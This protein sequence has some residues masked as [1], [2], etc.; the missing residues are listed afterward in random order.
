MKKTLQL[1]CL[2]TGPIWPDLLINKLKRAPSIS[3][4]LIIIFSLI[5]TGWEMLKLFARLRGM[6]PQQIVKEFCSGILQKYLA[7]I[8]I[9][10][11][12]WQTKEKP[13]FFPDEIFR[14]NFHNRIFFYFDRPG[15][16]WAFC[17]IAWHETPTNC[18]RGQLLAH[19]GWN[20][21]ICW[22]QMW[23]LQ[24]G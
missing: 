14:L 12:S 20:H 22:P 18:R 2:I 10:I 21:R 6:K 23:H 3:I 13:E 24:R 4:L 7:W 15:N 1:V 11:F 5:L 17:P 16:A 19:G 9:N 8:F